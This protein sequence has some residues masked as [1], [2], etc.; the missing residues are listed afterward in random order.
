MF[1]RTFAPVVIFAL[2][3]ACPLAA[4]NTDQQTPPA[5]GQTATSSA[6][7]EAAFAVAQEYDSDGNGPVAITAYKRF[8]KSY[9]ASPLASKAQYRIAEL[10]DATGNPNRA[11]D[12]YQTLLSRYP[13]T[14]EFEK[15]V[16][17]QVIIANQYLQGKRLIFLGMPV[18]PGT[19]RAQKMYEAILKNAP[20]SKHAPVAQFNLGLSLERQGLVNEAR[21]A[22]QTVLDKYPTSD[23]GDDALYQIAY[24]Y[25]QQ[26]L[27]GNSQDLSSLVLSKETFE[28][29]LLQYPKS[30]KAAQARDNLANIG[31]SE[32]GNLMRIARFYDF[33][34]DYKA[35]AIYYN[36]IVR[37]QPKT[38][39]AEIAKSRIE[40]IR[41]E[42]GDEGLRVGTDKAETGEKLAL[43]RRLQAQV[44]TSSLS[45]YSG[46][47]KRDI[48]PDELPIVK[49]PKFRT[50][51]RDLQPLPAPVEPILPTP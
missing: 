32:A 12:A 46:P 29:F 11:F 50:N 10:L 27:S 43:R 17:Q 6:E 22:Y 3:F 40:E 39:D 44:E 35:A 34:K 21:Q 24:I 23:V 33:T 5:S 25:M 13:D 38:A 1:F 36:D 15:A 8:I 9:A 49:Q 31:D 20:F 7:A 30:E 14:S 26:G 47:P 4:Q 42:V 28:D 45:D 41:G 2:V 48:V 37:K 51:V 19:E 18:L 16:A